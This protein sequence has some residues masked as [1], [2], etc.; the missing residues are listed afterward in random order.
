MK[1]R[2][3]PGIYNISKKNIQVFE[4]HRDQRLKP[5]INK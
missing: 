3:N 5:I 1:K 2:N 4:T